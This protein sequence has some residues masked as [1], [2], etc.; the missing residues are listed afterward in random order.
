MPFRCLAFCFLIFFPALPGMAM[1]ETLPIPELVRQAELILLGQVER[2]TDLVPRQPGAVPASPRVE[3]VVK[4]VQVL[5][6]S[7]PG[8]VLTF[9]TLG[10]I[11][12]VPWFEDEPRF[13]PVGRRVFLFLRRGKQGLEPVNLLQ[14][15]WPIAP[16]GV[17]IQ[18]M[19]FGLTIEEI[20]AEIRKQSGSQGN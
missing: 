5:K 8:P 3:T 15:V 20:A 19:G 6:G 18:G 4:P 17:V 9:V 10:T 14:G 13:P 12:G 11:A 1:I 16:D 2:Q 7:T